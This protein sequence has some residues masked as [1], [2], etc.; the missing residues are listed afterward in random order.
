[1]EAMSPAEQEA[2]F[3]KIIRKM[4]SVQD[5]LTLEELA[6]LS[7]SMMLRRTT[8]QGLRTSLSW[9]IKSIIANIKKL[10]PENDHII[11]MRAASLECIKVLQ[12]AKSLRTSRAD[13]SQ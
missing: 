10:P 7:L 4:P 6:L 8:S 9:K 11:V 5:P 13:Q 1:M 3:Q 12:T 2:L